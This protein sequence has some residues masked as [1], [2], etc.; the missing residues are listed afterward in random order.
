MNASANDPQSPH[1][2]SSRETPNEE[3]RR[4][5]LL[6]NGKAHPLNGDAR[7]IRI[8]L[9]GLSWAQ[10]IR[11]PGWTPLASWC[12]KQSVPLRAATTGVRI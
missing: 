11:N 4:M 9:P 2:T 10:A 1:R 3:R 7:R 6:V 8:G 5:I 12:D